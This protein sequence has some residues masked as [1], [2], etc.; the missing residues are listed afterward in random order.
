MRTILLGAIAAVTLSTTAFANTS[1]DLPLSGTLPRACEISAF[2]NGPFDA[3]D[4]TS[5]AEQ[6][7]ESITVNCNY[8]GTATVDLTSANGGELISGDNAI[9][10]TVSISGGLL[11][12]ASL[13]S[14][15]TIGNWPAV[16]NSD[17]SRSISV[18]LQNIATVAGTYTDTITATVTP[19]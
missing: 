16:A 9:P 5:T 13:S 15:Q 12:N 3:L 4:L 17:Q 10:Y 6:G 19:N 11:T 1:V 2:V 14:E 7:A 8:G 18:A